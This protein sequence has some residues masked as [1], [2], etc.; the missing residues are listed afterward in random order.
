MVQFIP[1]RNDWADAFKEIGGG[2]VKGYTN[3]SDENAVKKSIMDL[4]ENPSPRQIL[5]AVTNTKTYSPEAKKTAL[6]NYLGHEKFEELKRHA[7]AQEGIGEARNTIASNKETRENNK[8]ATERTNT[9]SIVNQLDLPEEQKEAL[10][11]TISQKAAED[12]LKQQLKP[13][14]EQEAKLSPFDRAVQTKNAEEYINLSKEIPKIESTL[15]DIAY[16]R[17]LSDELGLQ[18]VV[19]GTLGVSGKAKELENVSFTLMEPII[20]MFNPSGPIAQQKLKMIQDKYAI[21]AS[22]APWTKKAKLDSLERFANQALTRA[23]QKLALIKQYD[24]N[25]PT[26]VIEKFDRESETVSDAILDYDL[27]GEEVKD[28]EAKEKGMPSAADFKGKTVT[29]PDGQ[30]YH[31]DGTRWVKK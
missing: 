28:E 13:N 22:D 29:S 25:P 11:E 3:R 5:D 9:K 26:N 17:Q 6:S 15:G 24:G 30:K 12:L 19:T 8:V 2:L 27:V 1:A 10:G 14:K 31:S 20:K 4:G 21:K 18:G 23:N 16:A 7:K